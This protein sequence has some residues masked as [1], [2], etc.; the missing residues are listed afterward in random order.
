MAQHKRFQDLNLAD[1]YLFAAALEDAETCRIAL[2]ILLGRDVKH[3][4]VHA[5]HSVLFSKDY[6]SIRLDVYAK[7]AEGSDFNVEMQGDN[8][9]NLPKR[10]RYH[11][12]QMDVMSV[13]PGSDF[14]ELCPS[15]V[16][17][18]CRFDPFGGGFY[19]YTFTNRCAENGSELGDGTVKIFLNT[20][21]RNA[22][23][24]PEELV[25]FLEYVENSTAE[26]VEK[27]CGG[28]IGRIHS[29]VTAVKESREWERKYMTFG[30]LLD[31]EHKDGHKEGHKEGHREGRN[32]S[33]LLTQKMIEA[34]EAG[35]I[36]RLSDESFY[37][38]MCLKYGI[39]FGGN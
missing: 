24:V 25:H 35:Q 21:G 16:V 23:E 26:C 5:E 27:R 15:Y 7:D 20:K 12:S 2:E 17:F 19:R 14:N 36:S 34:G 4:T 8:E 38:E 29:R 31:K 32:E 33:I 11:Q 1:A 39:A 10:S 3:V 18:I 37:A 13:P 22:S 30:E 9:G 6:R 28:R